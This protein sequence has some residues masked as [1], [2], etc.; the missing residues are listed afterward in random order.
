ML[1]IKEIDF[2]LKKFIG[3]ETDSE[4][5]EINLTK[6]KL[7]LVFNKDNIII[8]KEIKKVKDKDKIFD[9]VV[10]EE[11]ESIQEEIL[12]IIEPESIQEEII[13]IIEPESI[14][15]E[16]LE[17]IEPESIQEEI[18]EIIEPELIQEEII[19]IIEPE[20]IQEIITLEQVK[21]LL[22]DNIPKKNTFETYF[23]TI[24]DV[25][26]HFKI[27]DIR[28]LLIT[29]EQEIINYI[30]TKYIKKLST[31]K[32]KVCC[33]YKAYKLLNIE[34][35]LF[36]KTIEKYRI[37]LIIQ[38]DED[39]DIKKQ[40]I[41]EGEKIIN[42]FN[43]Y[44]NELKETLSNNHTSGEAIT[45]W[46]QDTQLY[47]LLKIYLTYGVLRPS[48]IIDCKI[49][50]TDDNNDKINYINLKTKK[51]VINNHK[52]DR[53]G[54]KIIDITDPHLIKVLRLGLNNNLITKND[55]KLYQSSS[56]FSKFFKSKYYYNVY[57]LR[58]AI[59]SKCIALGDVEQIK[60]LEYIQGHSLETILN[61]YNQYSKEKEVKKE[62]TREFIIDF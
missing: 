30:E 55:G 54:S 33:F 16:I 20:S 7:K 39:K 61:H 22:N 11:N 37:K 28:E 19:E 47:A 10:D 12:E 1:I 58:K 36:K 49:T 56:A 51:I 32:N 43:N 17:I 38:I 15:K 18:L 40:T 50:D 35:E 4:L 6:T 52:N 26:T 45:N 60:R 3:L 27:I 34:S 14:Q 31:K 23:R 8:N 46:T 53:N 62:D 29:K 44:L 13:E 42:D 57:D 21:V 5:T 25:Y 48:E 9:V 41:D 24:K 59:S 2:V